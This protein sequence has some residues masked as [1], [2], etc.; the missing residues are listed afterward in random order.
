[1][2]FCRLNRAVDSVLNGFLCNN[3]NSI[4]I[5]AVKKLVI[6]VSTRYGLVPITATFVTTGVY[7]YLLRSISCTVQLPQLT[8]SHITVFH[9]N[10]NCCKNLKN[11]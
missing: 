6:H 7:I 9:G 4:A 8:V 3:V 2:D 11:Q 1:M 5:E 10:L